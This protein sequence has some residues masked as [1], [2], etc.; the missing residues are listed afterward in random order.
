MI[1]EGLKVILWFHPFI[2]YYEKKWQSL[3]PP[4]AFSNKHFFSIGGSLLLTSALLISLFSFNQSSK[5]INEQNFHSTGEW[6]N[7]YGDQTMWAVEESEKSFYSL[8]WGIKSLPL[9]SPNESE[10]IDYE[11]PLVHP[12]L[13]YTLQYTLPEMKGLLTPEIQE[14]SAQIALP[15]ST[16]LLVFQD[17]EAF[18]KGLKKLGEVP[19]C[20]V[21]LKIIDERNNNWFAACTIS[22]SG[23]VYGLDHIMSQHSKELAG[24][25]WHID[26]PDADNLLFKKDTC[27]FKWGDL[28]IDLIKYANPNV[29]S[30]YLELKKE[31]LL[32]FLHDSIRILK[33]GEFLELTDLTL[34]YYDKA[35]NEVINLTLILD[36]SDAYLRSAYKKRQISDMLNQGDAITI[37][38]K[39]GDISLNAVSIRI[40]NPNSLYEPKVWFSSWKKP[41]ETYE[42]QVISREGFKTKLRIDTTN[43]EVKHVLDLY[44]DPERYDIIHIPGFQTFRRL[45]HSDAQSYDIQAVKKYP[46]RDWFYRDQL[47]ENLD[48]VNHLVQLR[49]GELFAMPNSEIYS[50][51]EFLENID[52]PIELWFD[53]KQVKIK[54]LAVA[55]IPKEGDPDFLLLDE[56]AIQQFG[57]MEAIRNLEPAT[58]LFISG[59]TFED[60]D[61]KELRFP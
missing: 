55:I 60:E 31:N 48:Y 1:F 49:W 15:N 54:R 34:R 17:L 32:P 23:K 6:L 35:N 40:Y 61:G 57:K 36:G 25:K 21:F 52:Q 42:F 29:Y 8:R 37:Y 16:E 12:K 2:Y 38:G 5:L 4:Q 14:F 20:T 43:Q 58:S 59:M 22:E 7:T 19:E 30:G 46:D 11:I 10:V 45:V 47:P 3:F 53:K 26:S 33:D 44:D 18:E 50:P 9:V 56:L 41:E 27:V 24:I 13:F 28:S 51:E 39:A